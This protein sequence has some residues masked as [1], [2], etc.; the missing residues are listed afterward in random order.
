MRII[1][2]F[3]SVFFILNFSGGYTQTL[4]PTK[5]QCLVEVSLTDF[6]EYPIIYAYLTFTINPTKEKV[7]AQTNRT[8]KAFVLIPKK[9]SYEI[10]VNYRNDIFKFDKLFSIP[11]DEGAYTLSANLKYQ[12]KYIV[13]YEVEFES[14]KAGVLPSSFKELNRVVEM[15]NTKPTMKIEVLGHTDSIGNLDYNMK[16]SKKRAYSVKEYLI[17]QNVDSTRVSSSGYG[18][19]VP[20]GDNQTE[21]GRQRNRRIEVRITEE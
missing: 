1:A 5:E 18:P 11:Q 12:S 10:E 9:E 14:N 13:L 17:K 16:L 15:M 21:E 3:C 7:Y 19:T 4:K 6:E 8:G 2:F 20:I